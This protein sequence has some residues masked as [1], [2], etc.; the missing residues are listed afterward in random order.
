MTLIHIRLGC[1]QLRFLTV[2]L[3]NARFMYRQAR[4][5]DK[6]VLWLRM[7]PVQRLVSYT[8]TRNGVLCSKVNNYMKSM[9]WKMA[10]FGW[11]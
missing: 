5:Y 2:R 11:L 1:M 4:L 8:Y 10:G 9:Y 6:A 7:H 3:C